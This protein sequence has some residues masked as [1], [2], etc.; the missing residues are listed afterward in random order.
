MNY[1]GLKVIIYVFFNN[2]DIFLSFPILSFLFLSFYYDVAHIMVLGDY[3]KLSHQGFVSISAPYNRFTKKIRNQSNIVFN[4]SIP[5]N[6]S[7]MKYYKKNKKGLETR[8]SFAFIYIFII[9]PYFKEVVRTILLKKRG[10][11]L[12]KQEKTCKKVTK[13]R[14]T[15]LVLMKPDELHY[16]NPMSI[17]HYYLAPSKSVPDLPLELHLQ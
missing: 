2:L 4:D 15:I 17:P 7:T 14:Y 16:Q 5:C 9:F 8:L 1:K 13:K 3:L 11:T 12:K 6:I 10:I